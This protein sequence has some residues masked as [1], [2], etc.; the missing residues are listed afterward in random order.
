MVYLDPA[1]ATTYRI[2]GD[3]FFTVVRAGLGL[4]FVF[5]EKTFPFA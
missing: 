1:P 2:R 4:Y 3:V 5:A